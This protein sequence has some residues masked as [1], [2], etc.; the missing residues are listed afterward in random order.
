MVGGW[1]LGGGGRLDRGCDPTPATGP[2]EEQ[3][4][5][6]KDRAIAGKA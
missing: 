2:G 5:T 1:G 4:D 6:G 3:G